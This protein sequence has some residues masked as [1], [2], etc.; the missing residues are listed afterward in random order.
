MVAVPLGAASFIVPSDGDLARQADLIIEGVVQDSRSEL[1]SEGRIV[2]ISNIHIR[3]VLKGDVQ[4]STVALTAL[5][6]QV[7]D[8]ILGVSGRP[9]YVAREEVLVFLERFDGGFR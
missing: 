8:F 5:G 2:T 1:D 4:T 7:G 9:T 6:G 3:E